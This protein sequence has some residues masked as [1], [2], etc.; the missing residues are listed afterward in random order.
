[1]LTIWFVSLPICL[2]DLI[3]LG[4]FG[5]L[6]TSVFQ[7]LFPPPEG[8][9]PVK[10]PKTHYDTEKEADERVRRRLGFRAPQHIRM[11][12]ERAHLLC[13][14]AREVYLPFEDELS[15][16]QEGNFDLE[17]IDT[18]KKG[19]R[20]A[21]ADSFIPRGIDPSLEGFVRIAG[22]SVGIGGGRA[23][24]G[25][26]FGS[27]CRVI[28]YL[29]EPKGLNVHDTKAIIFRHIASGALIISFQGTMTMKQVKT[30]MMQQKICVSLDTY[31]AITS[32]RERARR[33]LKSIVPDAVEKNLLQGAKMKVNLL[34]LL[35]CDDDRDLP[36]YLQSSIKSSNETFGLGTCLMHF[37]FWSSYNRI[38]REIHAHVR[39][40]LVSRPGPLFITG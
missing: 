22:D 4:R 7:F 24:T 11:I 33:D 38:R 40:E 34:D 14:C 15:V 35:N 18:D 26:T 29:S 2:S 31:L 25:S 20:R 19:K 3:G 39:Q 27:G 5:T 8:L 36:D 21:Y 10:T 17:T 32:K 16:T 37:G 9:G 13:I 6:F 1:M 28:A 12:L 23:P 30:D